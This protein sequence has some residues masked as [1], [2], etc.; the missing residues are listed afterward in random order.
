M[1]VKKSVISRANERMSGGNT[2]GGR[3]EREPSEYDGIWIN[4]GIFS[5]DPDNEEDEGNFVR[6]PKGVAVS[7]LKPRKV[8]SGGDPDRAAETALMNS[9]IEQI[10]TQGLELAEGE[11]INLNLSVQLY[12]KQDEVETATT[13]HQAKAD[14]HNVLFG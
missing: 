9:I 2:G 11:S 1:A 14:L 13:D 8:Y 7:D 12:R 6:L 5:K 3:Y 10:Q 4:L